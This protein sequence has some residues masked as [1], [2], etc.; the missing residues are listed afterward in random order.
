MRRSWCC[1]ISVAV[2]IA[3]TSASSAQV[4]YA[5]LRDARSEPGSWLTYSGTYSGERFSPLAEITPSN[6][7][8]LRPQWIYQ[9][10]EA[11]PVE[12]T[13]LVA[14]GVMMTPTCA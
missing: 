5:R 8:G 2:C 4:P 7:A 13:P 11:G 1:L 6:A 3:I 12:V 10:Q 9:V 14:D